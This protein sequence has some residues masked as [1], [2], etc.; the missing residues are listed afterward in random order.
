MLYKLKETKLC[1]E[2]PEQVL[3]LLS[4]IIGS[5]THDLID[6]KLILED[7]E[8]ASPILKKKK[9]FKNLNILASDTSS[10]Y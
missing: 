3:L 6:L 10:R 7:I 5:H 2:Y 4:K 8:K 1:Q 9:N